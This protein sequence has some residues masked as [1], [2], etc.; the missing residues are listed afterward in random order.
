MSQYPI[1][2]DESMVGEYPA[3]S[4]SGGGYFY[5]EVL[6]YRVW[7]RPWEGAPDEYDGEIY[8]HAF[9]TFEK[10]LKF[11]QE[12]AGAEYP[13]VLVRQREWINEPEPGK[14]LHETGERVTE[15]RVEWLDDGKRTEDSIPQMLGGRV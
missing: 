8:F 6:E 10:A 14:F 11:S 13:L 2:V 4:K 12:T 9:A 1:A 15:W 3:L 5:D 7:C